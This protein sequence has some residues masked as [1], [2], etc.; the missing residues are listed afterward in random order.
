[1]STRYPCLTRPPAW[2][3]WTLLSLSLL[4]AAASAQSTGK[5]DFQY[6]GISFTIPEGWVGQEVDGGYLIGSHTQPGLVMLSLHDLASVEALRANAA[7]G[8]VEEGIM[9]RPTGQLEGVGGNG[10]G[11]EY[12]GTFSGQQVKAYIVGLVNPNGNGVT[13][14]AATEPAKYNAEYRKLALAVANSTRFSTPEK[15]PIVDEWKQTLRDTQLTYM[16]SYYSS[17]SSYDGYS[18]GG[19]Y[20]SK[21]KIDLCAA[22]HFTHSS[23][24]SVSID[25]GGAYGSSAGRGGGHGSWDV[26][27]GAQG[28]AVLVLNFH[29]GRSE[30]YNLG[31]QDKKTLLNGKRWFRTNDA[32]CY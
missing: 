19:G 32:A 25:T 14:M 12:A 9:L 30:Q 10:I 1:M 23:R 16:D 2:L 6:L 8:I 5:V 4:A 24:S 15:P 17:G 7:Q 18:T 13:I 21:I 22:G 31:Y 3:R 26:V 11:G 27:G 28:Q 29:D 20:S